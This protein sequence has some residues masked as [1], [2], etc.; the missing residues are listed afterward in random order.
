MQRIF[1]MNVNCGWKPILCYCRPPLAPWWDSFID[2][3]S[4]EKEKDLHDWQQSEA[5]A[6]YFIDRLC[7]PGGVVLDPFCG[8]GTTLAAAQK[9]GRQWLGIELDEATALIATER[10][11]TTEAPE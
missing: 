3:T 5:E 1:K 2:I 8:S 7:P 6:G 4:G 11:A 9:L 10:L